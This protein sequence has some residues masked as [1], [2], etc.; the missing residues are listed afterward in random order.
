MEAGAA[1][2]RERPR[3]TRRL[4]RAGRA[5]TQPGD[6]DRGLHRPRPRP[7]HVRGRDHAEGRRPGA[8][9]ARGLRADGLRAARREQHERDG[10][11]R[12]R[13]ARAV[14]GTQPRRHVPSLRAPPAGRA[15]PRLRRGEGARASAPLR[16]RRLHE[17]AGLRRTRRGRRQPDRAR[18]FLRPGPGLGRSS[19]GVAA[20]RRV[21]DVPRHRAA[22]GDHLP[23]HAR[24]A[25]PAAV[26]GD[27]AARRQRAL[28][29]GAGR[30]A[31]DL[32]DQ[33]VGRAPGR[34]DRHL[35]R[36]STTSRGRSRSA[37]GA[38]ATGPTTAAAPRRGR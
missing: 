11:L 8:G 27:P 13:P 35:V 37:P 14:P 19:D 2:P 1:R 29:P 38:A 21:D 3:R 31:A 20:G 36:R 22:E 24:R 25:A 26:S 28:Q 15:G 30:A 33:A 4:P 32:R 5:A 18:L 17:G 9:G 6:L 23:L 10:L 34:G 7:R 16:R 12:A